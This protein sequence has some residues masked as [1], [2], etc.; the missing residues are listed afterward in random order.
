MAVSLHLQEGVM[1]E[2]PVWAFYV[3]V[4]VHEVPNWSPAVV[5]FLDVVT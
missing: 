5:A 3:L 1:E 4:V 2:G